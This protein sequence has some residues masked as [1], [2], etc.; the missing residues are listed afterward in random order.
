MG[1]DLRDRFEVVED[2]VADVWGDRVAVSRVG[3]G[4]SL[5]LGC[6]GRRCGG[7]RAAG[8]LLCGLGP[9]FGRGLAEEGWGDG[10]G[11]GGG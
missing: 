9:G 4:R 8:R 2:L 10:R 3:G 7:W 6:W 5:R 11:G 1:A